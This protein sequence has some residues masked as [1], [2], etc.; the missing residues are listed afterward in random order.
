MERLMSEWF[1]LS[2]LVA[3]IFFP[4]LCGVGSGR[5]QGI[6]LK[7]MKSFYPHELLD[8]VLS[9]YLDMSS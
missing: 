1:R 5:G 4:F 9:L 7:T 6:L 2:S 8:F 3:S